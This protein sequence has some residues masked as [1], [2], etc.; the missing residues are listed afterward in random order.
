MWIRRLIRSTWLYNRAIHCRPHSVP[1]FRSLSSGTIWHSK[2]PIKRRQFMFKLSWIT[3]RPTSIDINFIGSNHLK[4][5]HYFP[6]LSSW[7][8]ELDPVAVS[9]VSSY[10]EK[11]CFAFDTTWS[12]TNIHPNLNRNVPYLQYRNRSF[13]CIRAVIDLILSMGIEGNELV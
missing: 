1:S 6:R 7:S 10:H 12:I 3:R 2:N 13:M 5:A 4:Q 8:S 11:S 9:L